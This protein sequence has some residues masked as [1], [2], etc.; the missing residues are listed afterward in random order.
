M[1]ERKR[2]PYGC[3]YYIDVEG[4]FRKGRPE[5]DAYGYE[6]QREK[7]QRHLPP[8]PSSRPTRGITN[9]T[10]EAAENPVIMLGVLAGGVSRGI[11][12]QERNGQA[13]LVTSTSLPSKMRG[14]MTDNARSI[15]EGFGIKFGGASADDPL[16]ID[17]TLPP[18][19]RKE[20]TNHSMWSKLLDD[21][22]RERASIFYKAAFYDRDAHMS[23]ESRFR[24]DMDYN[25]DDYE[26]VRS[27]RI[28]DG[29]KVVFEKTFTLPDNLALALNKTPY[30]MELREQRDTIDQQGRD[31]CLA[32]VSER[33]PDWKNPA[34]HWDD[35]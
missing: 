3:P 10:R 35:P 32:W 21:K 9:T 29:G 31:A 12:E 19:W 26:T 15:F 16:F 7:K 27:W 4:G 2:D 6:V 28:L 25:R 23:V 5:V 17:A 20:R 8:G 24:M 11:E 34:A 14:H 22:G 30:D 1:N 13:E 18:G 33:Y